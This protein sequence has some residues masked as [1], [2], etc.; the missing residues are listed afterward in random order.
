MPLQVSFNRANIQHLRNSTTT[1][2]TPLGE[3]YFQALNAV[4]YRFSCVGGQITRWNDLISNY[5]DLFRPELGDGL[6]YHTFER[7]E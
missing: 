1:V 3:G 4:R 7:A 5:L 6:L 2:I